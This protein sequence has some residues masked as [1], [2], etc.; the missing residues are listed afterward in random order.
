MIGV[1]GFGVRSIRSLHFSICQH[2]LVSK[3]RDIVLMVLFV[4][5]LSMEFFRCFPLISCKE[6]TDLCLRLN[7]LVVRE[8]VG[9]CVLTFMELNYACITS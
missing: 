6:R 3:E 8:V 1:V 5:G 2:L 4:E 9:S 7:L